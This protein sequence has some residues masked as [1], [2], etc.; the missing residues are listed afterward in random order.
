MPRSRNAGMTRNFARSGRRRVVAWEASRP[1]RS[2]PCGTTAPQLA[3]RGGGRLP[4]AVTAVFAAVLC[5]AVLVLP[6]PAFGALRLLGQWGSAGTGDGQFGVPVGIVVANGSVY[7]SDQRGKT[8]LIQRFGLSGSFLGK[9]AAPSQPVGGE[10][11]QVSAD[12]AGD[13]YVVEEPNN[14]G[15]EKFSPTGARST[16]WNG[17]GTPSGVFLEPRGVVAGNGNVYVSDYHNRVAEFTEA[18]AFIRQWGSAG[19][20]PGQFSA[21]DHMALDAVGNLYVLDKGNSR[22]EKFDANGA[23]L[24]QWGMSTP[25]G[26]LAPASVYG[27]TGIA[28]GPSGFVYVA[29]NYRFEIQKFTSGGQLVTVYPSGSGGVSFRPSDLAFDPLGNMFVVADQHVL[30]FAESSGAGLPAPVLGKSGNVRP[31]SGRV[32]VSLKGRRFVPLTGER[33]LPVGAILD[34]SRG[35]VQLTSAANTRGAI[36]SGDFSAGVFQVL[37]PR[38]L[39]GLTDLN[40][41]GGSFR[42]CS[43]RAGRSAGAVQLSSRVIRRLRGKAR[44]RFRTR[45]RYSAATVRGTVWD[46]ID[47][48]DGTLTRVQSGVVVVRDLRKRRNITLRAGKSYLAKA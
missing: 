39:G 48:C 44:G 33:Q 42:R 12:R 32:F 38:R 20:G 23:F 28:V 8:P 46:T 3:I 36:Q 9:W 24:A 37:Q 13:I 18:G 4:Y 25:N 41:T 16:G 6:P 21:P 27:A 34:T 40:L 47:R 17:T 2:T 11:F 22:I 5:A 30:K 7:V 19:S 45:G 31:V 26:T 10:P 35:T 15:V 1:Q 29:N 43:A 14:L